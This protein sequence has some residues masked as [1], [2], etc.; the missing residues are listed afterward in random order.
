MIQTPHGGIDV[1][2]GKKYFRIL[3]FGDMHSQSAA[4]SKALSPFAGVK[5]VDWKF[6]QIPN[7]A[8]YAFLRIV[9][10]TFECFYWSLRIFKEINKFHADII[11]AE[12]AYFSGLIGTVA[13]TA[14]RKKCVIY[15]VGSDLKIDTR[16]L[17]GM[18]LVSWELRHSSGI[19]CVS[20]DLEN[21][22]KLLGAKNTIAIPPPMDFSDCYEKNFRKDWEIISVAA[23]DPVKALS[24][25]IRAMRRLNDAKLLIIGDGPERE[26]L[27]SLS[28]NLGLN[29]RVFFLGQVRH[30]MV[31]DFLQ[32]AEVFVLPSV[33]EG[34]PRAIIEAMVCGLPVVATKVGGIP[35]VITNGVNGF[36]VPS[37]NEDALVEAIEKLLRDVN[38]RKKISNENRKKA[39]KYDM[40]IIG[41]R[42]YDYLSIV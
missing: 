28:Q 22:A 35:E 6:K 33:S 3:V 19:I 7:K 1:A 29:S 42:M 20:K 21:I 10:R 31:W 26:N 13:A 34:C 36:L 9:Y 32:K 8:R 39:T 5:E 38:L 15:S 14:S 30:S 18:R 12:Y 23:L 37:Q 11:I 41:Q 16:S 25:L 40:R 2:M 4:I 27:K 24:Y 17:L